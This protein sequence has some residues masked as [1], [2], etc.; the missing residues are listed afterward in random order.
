MSDTDAVTNQSIYLETLHGLRMLLD[1]DGCVTVVPLDR[2]E[3]HVETLH[4][5]FARLKTFVF[6]AEWDEAN[7]RF[8]LATDK[9]TVF[10]RVTICNKANQLVLHF[11]RQCALCNF[12]ET[13]LHDLLYVMRGLVIP[14]ARYEEVTYLEAKA[15]QRSVEVAPTDETRQKNIAHA[16]SKLATSRGIVETHSEAIELLDENLSPSEKLEL[17]RDLAQAILQLFWMGWKTKMLAAHV[18]TKTTGK[19]PKDLADW[20]QELMTRDRHRCTFEERTMR[21]ILQDW[22]VGHREIDLN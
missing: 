5:V 20:V 1:T 19:L 18:L 9:G 14:F 7:A 13:S 12:K 15:W 2:E 10:W 11:N 22:F 16:H 8:N 4:R 17:S 6:Y 21:A 3:K